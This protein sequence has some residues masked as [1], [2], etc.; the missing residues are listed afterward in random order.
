M[1]VSS[2]SARRLHEVDEASARPRLARRLYPVAAGLLCVLPV[3]MVVAHRS[4]PL[5]ITLAAAVALGGAIA[6]GRGRELRDSAA[7]LVRTPLG[8]AVLAFL[9]W[10]VLCT[11]RSPFPVTSLHML[12]EFCLPV[13]AAF[14]LALA[15]PG[16]I[17]LDVWGPVAG[18]CAILA[19][20]LI[21]LDIRSDLALRGAMGARAQSYVLNRP[22]L[23][24]LVL[25]PALIV[26]LRPP[27]RWLA[28]ILI[29]STVVAIGVSVSGTAKLGAIAAAAAF[30]LA[31]FSPRAASWIVGGL[32]LGALAIAPRL[33]DAAARLLPASVTERL[34]SAHA[35]DRVDIWR[36]FGAA[37]GES[38]LAGAGFG[39][40]GRYGET[41]AAS[42]VASDFRP[43]LDIGHPHNAPLQIWAETGAVGAFLAALV[44]ALT[45]RRLG[46]LSGLRFAAALALVAAALAVAMVGQGAWQGWWPAGIGAAILWFRLSGTE[47]V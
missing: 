18:G 29:A 11:A 44:A 28:A 40:S 14:L 46:D 33:G 19:G 21:V 4:S 2:P 24:L 16:R 22:A 27:R 12:G 15:L 34:S 37:I 3:A 36:S 9:A 39:T 41:E 45:M 7:D 42:R 43:L 8:A 31:W 17:D 47:E 10:A 6:E 30:A 38:P 5:V 35:Q 26:V 1:T 23:T 13:A 32:L 20:A 25:A